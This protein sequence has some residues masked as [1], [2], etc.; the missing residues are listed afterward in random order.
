M[1]RTNIGFQM[2]EFEAV[3]AL[4][5][6]SGTS[7]DGIEA[8]LIHTDGERVFKAG[9]ACMKPYSPAFREKLRN[10]L[11]HKEKNEKLSQFFGR[12]KQLI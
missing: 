10:A 5:L 4:G 3:W 8:A 9:P 7:L 12:I 2:G 1:E 11:G 6:M